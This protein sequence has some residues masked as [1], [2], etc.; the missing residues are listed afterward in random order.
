[1]KHCRMHV[2]TNP[3]APKGNRNAQKHGAYSAKTLE[4]VRHFKASARI[5][6]YMDLRITSNSTSSIG[7]KGNG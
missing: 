3:G 6:R 7:G 1:M 2:G 5:V 4:A